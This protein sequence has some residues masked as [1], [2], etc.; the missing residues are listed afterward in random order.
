[1]DRRREIG[2]GGM[3]LERED[4][5][6]RVKCKHRHIDTGYRANRHCVL[7]MAEVLEEHSSQARTESC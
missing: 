2:Q 4:N 1:M 3:S 7:I 6:M 5:V